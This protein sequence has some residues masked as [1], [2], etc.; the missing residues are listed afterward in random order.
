MRPTYITVHSTQT[1][2][3][4]ADAAFWARGMKVGQVHGDAQSAGLPD[5]AFLGGRELGVAVAC[6]LK[7]RGEHADYEGN[8]NKRSVGIEMCENRGNSRTATVER[9]AKLCAALMKEYGIPIS[10]VVPHYHWE[11]IRPRTGKN[12]R[13]QELPEVPDG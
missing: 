13:T 2:S 8:G 9:T 10:H 12:L 5:L 7:E 3:S 4:N 6:R 11:R 1:Y